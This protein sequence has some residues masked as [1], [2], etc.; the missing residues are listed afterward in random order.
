MSDKLDKFYVHGDTKAS[1]VDIRI[2]GHGERRIVL[3][4]GENETGQHVQY[5]E[6]FVKRTLD[7]LNRE[8]GR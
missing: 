6:N 5:W 4:R 7:A 2:I 1:A 3:L 8:F